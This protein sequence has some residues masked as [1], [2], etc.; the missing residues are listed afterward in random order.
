MAKL[1]VEST[2]NDVMEVY[3][4]LATGKTYVIT[5]PSINS[6]GAR[7]ARGLALG[8]PKRVILLGRSETRI[9][10]VIDELKQL[11]SSISYVFV[12]ADL[13]DNSSVRKA[14][15]QIKNITKEIHGLINCAG[16]M[17]IKEFR[18][19][20][21]GVESQFAANHLG[22]FVLTNLLIPELATGHAVISNVTSRAHFLSD[23]NFEDPNFKNGETYNRWVAYAQSKTANI[24]FS[25]ALA[26]R[27]GKFDAVSF[28]VNPGMVFET[29]LQANS[30]LDAA[31]FQEGLDM[32]TARN[33]GV[34]VPHP[35]PVTLDQG[36]AA[37]LWS[38][39]DADLRKSSGAFLEECRIDTPMP[40]ASDPEAAEKLW[41]LSE[42]LVGEQFN[43]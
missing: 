14:A 27:V 41:Q 39:L 25:V 40:Y 36:A 8:N 2:I 3:K 28:S 7:V 24:L 22:H 37:I 32:G 4:P 35:P 42:R 21:D 18:K 11:N 10:P 9:Q 23:V 15:A 6:I 30:G 26:K 31:A 5:G 16:V 43:V 1:D 34:P 12:Q 38:V 17:A 20:K 29:S 19:T 33:G 13:Q